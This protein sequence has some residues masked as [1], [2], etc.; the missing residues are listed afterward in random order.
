MV[1]LSLKLIVQGDDARA[2]DSPDSSLARP[3][4]VCV[5]FSPN[6]RSAA[7]NYTKVLISKLFLHQTAADDARIFGSC[8]TF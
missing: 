4:S 6:L 8:F 2:L 7:Q 3:D 1:L 5:N